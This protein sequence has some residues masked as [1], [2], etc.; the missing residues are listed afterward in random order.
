MNQYDFQQTLNKY[1]SGQ[2]TQEEEDFVLEYFKNNPMEDSAVF[3]NEKEVIGKRIQAKLFRTTFGKLLILRSIPW[4]AAAASVLIAIGV[5][6]FV[7]ND[8]AEIAANADLI[9]GK[10]LMEFRNTS[11]KPQHVTLED[12]SIVTLKKNSSLSFPGHFGEK[13]RQV[14]LHGEAFFEI[15]RNTAK[16]F[17]VHAGDLV[18]KVLGTSFNIKSYDKSASVEVRVKTGRV[19]VYEGNESRSKT[20]N[21]V[22]LTPNQKIIFDKKSR[23]MEFSIVENPSLLIPA[24]ETDHGFTFSEIPV[25][26]VFAS[27]E[28]SYG[29][30][31]VLENDTADS[32]LFT[33][34]LN[35]LTLFQQ[36]D[37]ICKS[38]NIS[39]ERRGTALF[40]QG[41]GCINE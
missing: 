15:K 35:G 36:L 24:R 20:K 41:A 28:K 31:I 13:N 21:G 5:W 17:I 2:H 40:V 23:K 34:D 14:Y 26:S 30:D 33:G 27:L 37:L 4:L 25:K 39:Y 1:L 7:Q 19:S 32:C 16:P 3:E 9:T 38:A 22:I 10:G 29:I 12:G 8:P 11:D 18:T 6:V